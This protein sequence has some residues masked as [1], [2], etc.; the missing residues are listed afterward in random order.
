MS[1]IV[2]RLRAGHPSRQ[3]IR[4]VGHLLEEAADEI[5]RLR[6]SL[7]MI[8]LAPDAAVEIAR[9]AVGEGQP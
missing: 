6:T 7:S 3:T 1:D 9:A 8:I 5:E 2:E 4:D